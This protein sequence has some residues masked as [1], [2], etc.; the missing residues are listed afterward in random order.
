VP[1][2]SE[3]KQAIPS[4]YKRGHLEVSLFSWVNAYKYVFPT[5]SI[6]NAI[7]GFYHF[8]KIDSDTYPLTTAVKT[9]QRMN[10]E[11]HNLEKSKSQN[12]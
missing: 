8:Y 5:I 10:K 9:Y 3:F 4:L 7:N 2:E 6:E 11:L 12:K 1:K